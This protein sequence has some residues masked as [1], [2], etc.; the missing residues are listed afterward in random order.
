VTNIIVSS[1]HSVWFHSC[2]VAD[3]AFT[4]PLVKEFHLTLRRPINKNVPPN[5]QNAS[6]TFARRLSPVFDGLSKEVQQ[7]LIAYA[8][9]RPDHP[10]Q[11]VLGFGGGAMLH[12]MFRCLRCG[13]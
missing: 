6:A 11:R 13:R 3:T 5:R 7:S 2:G 9:A 10:V 4:V 8:Q 12:G 1:P